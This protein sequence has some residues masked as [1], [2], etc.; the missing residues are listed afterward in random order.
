[1]YTSLGR[2]PSTLAMPLEL[3]SMATSFS[4]RPPSSCPDPSVPLLPSSYLPLTPA[5]LLPLTYVSSILQEAFRPLLSLGIFIEVSSCVHPA[6]RIL[7]AT[8]PS[9]AFPQ[10]QSSSRNILDIHPTLV[11]NLKHSPPSPLLSIHPVEASLC[12]LEYTFGYVLII[13]F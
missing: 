7:V 11:G 10:S 12:P 1:M 3:G 2:T 5:P 8:Q 4:C 6:G 13:F 9:G